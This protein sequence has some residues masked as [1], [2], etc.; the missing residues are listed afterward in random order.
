MDKTSQPRALMNG[1]SAPEQSECTCALSVSD[2]PPRFLLWPLIAIPTGGRRFR[3]QTGKTGGDDTPKTGW[4]GGNGDER[5][6]PRLALRYS[7]G[8]SLSAEH[9]LER[10]SGVESNRICFFVK[11]RPAPGP[12]PGPPETAPGST[13]GGWAAGPA[14][15]NV[16]GKREEANRRRL[17]LVPASQLGE[18]IRRARG[19]ARSRRVCPLVPV[20]VQQRRNVWFTGR[21]AAAGR[22]AGWGGSKT[23]QANSTNLVGGGAVDVAPM[24]APSSSPTAELTLPTLLGKRKMQSAYLRR[25]CGGGASGVVRSIDRLSNVQGKTKQKLAGNG[26]GW[27]G[28]GWDIMDGKTRILVARTVDVYLL[29]MDS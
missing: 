7:S 14:A 5:H 3:R 13:A 10:T 24:P 23:K 11:F 19:R 1:C 27:D 29:F 15:S 20:G 6:H 25:W 9:T 22:A 18:P 26:M 4:G 2:Q 12:G 28:M 16:P 21:Q 8:S 17:A